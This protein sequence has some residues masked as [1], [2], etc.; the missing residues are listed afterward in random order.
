[1]EDY[2]AYQKELLE[3]EKGLIE[4]YPDQ[5]DGISLALA[6]ALNK[7]KKYLNK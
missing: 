2:K 6:Y 5:E 7:A 1:M 4:R 3:I